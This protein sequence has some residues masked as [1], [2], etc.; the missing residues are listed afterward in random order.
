MGEEP[1][2]VSGLHILLTYRCT[3]ECDHCFV[4][5]SPRQT[6][7]LG[8]EQIAQ[9]LAQAKDAGVQWIYFEGGEPF[10]YYAILVKGVHMAADMGFSVGV[11]SNAYWAV[12]V[13]DAAEWLRP[14]V[15]R[16]ADLTVSS[17]LFHCEKCLG[18]EPQNAMAAAKWLGIPTGMI[19]I[20]QP[21]EAAAQTH[22]QITDQGAVMFR[23]RAAAK[24]A[25]AASTRPW[26]ELTECPHED[27]RE[28]GRLHLDPFGNLHI[29]QGIS[30]G[31]VFER[32]LREI[33]DAYEAEAHPICGPILGGGPA[34]LVSEYNLDHRSGY[35]DACQL[36]YEARLA[37]RPRFPEILRPDQMYGANL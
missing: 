11:V 20:A 29:C 9:V 25:S 14:L 28:P 15:A 1:V 10:L 17:D 21:N 16:V 35:A 3:F 37:L 2:Q 19:S 23:G 7:V 30:I 33:C 18:E 8:I 24:L 12:S 6:G 27:L 26:A 32:P 13:A 22:G 5:G 4:W 31:N 36:C 34:A